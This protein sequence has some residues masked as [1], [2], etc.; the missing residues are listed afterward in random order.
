VTLAAVME[1]LTETLETAFSGSDPKIEVTPGMNFNPTPP[2]I[3]IYPADPFRTTEEAGYG[4]VSGAL[5]FIIRARVTT[6]EFDGA[7]DLLLRLMDDEDDL[8]LADALLDAMDVEVDG[9]SGF[10]QYIDS[11]RAGAWLGVQWTV[12]VLNASS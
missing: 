10:T 5:N 2:A 11:G 6:A 9:P 3:D 8:C 12:K 4:E 1:L 7:Q